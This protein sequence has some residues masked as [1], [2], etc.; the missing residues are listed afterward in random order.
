MSLIIPD[1]TFFIKE[2]LLCIF[3]LQPDTIT[4]WG[5]PV[6][7]HFVTTE[8]G[9]ILGVHRIPHGRNYEDNNLNIKEL[10]KPSVFLQHGLTSSSASYSWG[11]PD[12]SLAYILAD[13][14]K[15]IMKK[16]FRTFLCILVSKSER[17]K[18]KRVSTCNRL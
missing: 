11:P 10:Q 6:E 9:Y 4:F 12:K 8:D 5:Y 13:A 18:L 17:R 15:I 16:Y 1:F 3:T 7:E 14:G 2:I